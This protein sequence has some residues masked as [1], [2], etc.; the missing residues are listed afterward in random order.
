VEAPRVEAFAVEHC[1]VGQ[2]ADVRAGPYLEA[3]LG[4]ERTV[5]FGAYA[6]RSGGTVQ[7]WSAA[8]NHSPPEQEAK[9]EDE[10]LRDRAD[11]ASHGTTLS[12]GVVSYAG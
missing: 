12:V 4:R 6:A 9:E 8:A 2:Q 11:Q 7:P 3:R 5:E 1:A 10:S